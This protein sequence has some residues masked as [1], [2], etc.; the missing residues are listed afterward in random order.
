MSRRLFA[1]R[2][3]IVGLRARGGVDVWDLRD[4]DLGSESYL[5]LIPIHRLSGGAFARVGFS[6]DEGPPSVEMA[7]NCVGR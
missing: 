3:E 2:A 7:W 1:D 6:F 5:A 4:L